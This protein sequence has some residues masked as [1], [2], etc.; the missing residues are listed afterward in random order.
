MVRKVWIG[1]MFLQHY[2]MTAIGRIMQHREWAVFAVLTAHLLF[3]AVDLLA[4]QWRVPGPF[5]SLRRRLVG[6]AV[7]GLY[8]WMWNRVISPEFRPVLF[9]SISVPQFLVDQQRLVSLL[10]LLI[11]GTLLL[12]S[13]Q[14][15]LEKPVHEVRIIRAW[16]KW[17]WK[18]R[19]LGRVFYPGWPSG[20]VFAF[21]L[22]C[23]FAALLGWRDFE[24][25]QRYQVKAGIP[26]YNW[27][28]I[29]PY[30]W[31]DLLR[32]SPSHWAAF[33]GM[34]VMPLVLWQWLLPN[35]LRWNLFGYLLIFA[36]TAML[37]KSILALAVFMGDKGIAKWALP[38][39]AMYWYWPA[40]QR[41]GWREFGE[42]IVPGVDWSSGTIL[43]L[44]G[45]VCLAWWMAALAFAARAFRSVRV[46]ERKAEATL[47]ARPPVPDGSGGM[48]SEV[49]VFPGKKR[50]RIQGC[51]PAAE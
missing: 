42:V 45:V 12:V 3:F 50:P 7:V 21:L 10:S 31:H 43:I 36:G 32:R 51:G 33:T 23:S 37:Q 14:A 4:A 24:I 16:S 6:V 34:L 2:A 8:L 29:L 49:A 46:V 26:D 13:W 11:P 1:G 44:S 22:A 18:G 35:L 41:P 27:S 48:D 5:R 25:W 19:M 28:D 39:P 47:T 9:N 30:N 20:V 40:Y 15:M 38:F 17:G